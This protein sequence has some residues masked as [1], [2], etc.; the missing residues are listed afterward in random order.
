MFLEPLVHVEAEV[1][2]GPE[3]SGQRLSHDPGL[4]FGSTFRGDGFV[5]L[6][7]LAL[8]GLHDFRET[9]EGIAHVGGRQSRSSRSRI[10]ADFPAPTCDLIVRGS[11]GPDRARD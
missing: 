6:V 8:P 11:L 5:E 1:L 4:I 9:L 3:H 7:R 2:L 10:V